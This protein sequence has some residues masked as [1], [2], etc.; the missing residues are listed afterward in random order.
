VGEEAYDVA[1]PVCAHCGTA[2]VDRSTLV[3]EEGRGYCCPNCAA[4]ARGQTVHASAAGICAHCASA[5]VERRTEVER[6]GMLFCCRN[7]ATAMGGGEQ[8][9]APTY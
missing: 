7:C 2:L 4:M 5:I 9:T 1:E 6:D 3:E 8:P